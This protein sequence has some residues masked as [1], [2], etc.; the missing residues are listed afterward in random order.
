M[1]N[2]IGTYWHDISSMFYKPM[3]TLSLLISIISVFL[4][5]GC[6]AMKTAQ[7]ADGRPMLQPEG[8]FLGKTQ[9]TG[10]LE[11]RGGRPTKRITT[12]TVGT[13]ANGVLNIEQDLK[14]ENGR[15]TH[16]AWQ[17]RT[18]DAHHVDATAN[19]IAGT[20]HGTLYG[21]VFHWSFTLKL[22]PGNPLMNVRMSQTMYLQPDGKTLIIRSI[23]RKFGI[24]VAEI[25][26]QFVKK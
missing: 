5:S 23:I 7:F 16:R 4:L 25:T 15:T 2:Q 17:I 18:I 11:N 14:T 9:S 20:A 21:N 12:E 19:D 1:A 3:R 22:K 8:F 6:S 24:I 26:E 10:V 13:M